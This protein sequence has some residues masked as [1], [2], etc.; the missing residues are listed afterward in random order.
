M[1][2]EFPTYAGAEEVIDRLSD[3]GFPVEHSRI[4]G[5]GLHTMEY[6]TGR[7]TSKGAAL[8]GAATGAWF[9]LFIGLLLGMFSTGSAWL[10]V[11]FGSSALGALW[12]G[13]FA[14]LAH[15]AMR[16]KRD[17][18]SV[19][20]LEADQYAVQVDATHLDEARRI[21]GVL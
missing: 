13:T 14:F 3:N 19:K 4:V 1:L 20:S 15:W 7:L 21:S 2:G 5:N 16:G 8:A 6:V 11:L 9:G 10:A 17:F 18:S 12:M